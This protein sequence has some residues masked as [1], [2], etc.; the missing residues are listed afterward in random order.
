VF[1]RLFW[2]LIGAGF[3]FGMSF[4]VVRTVRATIERY[5]PERVSGDLAAAIREFGQDLRAAVAEGRTAMQERET[6]LRAELE[7]RAGR[8]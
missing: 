8:N 1:K 6:E 7:Q 5:T 3:G 2:L 4:W